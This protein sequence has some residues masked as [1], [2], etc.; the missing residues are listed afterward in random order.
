MEYFLYGYK[1]IITCIIL[2]TLLQ[3]LKS[4][5]YYETN[6][7]TYIK[8]TIKSLKNNIILSLGI[9]ITNTLMVVILCKCEDFI[10]NLE[11]LLGFIVLLIGGVYSIISGIGV[12][13]FMV[14]MS[15]SKTDKVFYKEHE[16][17]LE[18]QREKARRESEEYLKEQRKREK[19]L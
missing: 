4:K 19:E 1:P 6:F 17:H 12:P 18:K 14:S 10:F 8:N 9:I 15:K 5:G 16:K 13:V 3:G 11:G 7:I 2:V